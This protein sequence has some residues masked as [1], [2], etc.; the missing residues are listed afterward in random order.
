MDVD[1][2]ICNDAKKLENFISADSI[3]LSVIIPPYH[4]LDT[5]PSKHIDLI[6]NILRKLTKVTK[7]GGT[8][9]LIIS[10]DMDPDQIMDL[11]EIRALIEVQDDP[12]IGQKWI[13]ADKFIWVKSP[14]K[15]IE[16][17]NPRDDITIVSF[18]QTPFSTI[19]VL[20]RSDSDDYD[21]L[22]ISDRIKKLKISQAKKMEMLEPFWY[23]P[24]KSE[25]GYKDY[26]PKELILRL[27]LLFSKEQDLILDPFAGH[28]ITAVAAK[29]LN[30]HYLCVEK[31]SKKAELARK[32]VSN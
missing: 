18:E 3:D 32:R 10:E 22:N 25:K 24:P 27:I 11:T 9:C 29:T 6:K 31:N 23:I 4:K 7:L 2:I 13:F 21:E 30:R 19:V 12:E 17:L 28:G 8:C 5:N 14:K 15:A 16:S 1:R 26:F 20:V